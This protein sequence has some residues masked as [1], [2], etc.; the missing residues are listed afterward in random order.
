[1][2][3]LFTPI[4]SRYILI[5]VIAL[6]AVAGISTYK[7]D[8]FGFGSTLKLPSSSFSSASG[9]MS[10]ETYGMIAELGAVGFIGSA[11]SSNYSIQ[12]GISSTHTNARPGVINHFP[13]AYSQTVSTTSGTPITI[14]LTGSDIDGDTL[15]WGIE[16]PVNGGSISYKA[17]SETTNTIDVVFTPSVGFV[18][19]ASF[20]FNATDGS[21]N[22]K[23]AIVKINVL[24]APTPLPS[25]VVVPE[26]TPTP[27]PN[28]WDAPS[29][30]GWGFAALV[31]GMFLTIVLLARLLPENR[32]TV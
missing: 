21:L 20:V 18:G 26:T 27:V 30:S 24:Q 23:S 17:M 14:T 3:L 19:M 28:V 9:A 25:N 10:S 22:S 11:Q 15:G 8:V 6:Y 16:T 5:L 1:M 13:V 4:H 31:A 32:R 12:M 29:M 7:D 2:G